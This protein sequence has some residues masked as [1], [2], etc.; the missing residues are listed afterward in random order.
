MGGGW[1][2]GVGMAVKI[3]MN[4]MTRA[5]HTGANVQLQLLLENSKLK[6]SI[7]MSKKN[8]RITSHTGMSSPFDSKLV[9][10]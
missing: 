4:L 7:T 3:G 2:G 9:I 10:V 8:L 6:R 1:G 5:L